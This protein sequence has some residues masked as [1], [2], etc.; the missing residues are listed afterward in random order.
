VKKSKE[1]LMK[2][3]KNNIV[4]TD[5]VD[6]FRKDLDAIDNIEEKYKDKK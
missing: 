2:E 4:V 5:L 6:D 1:D 3:I